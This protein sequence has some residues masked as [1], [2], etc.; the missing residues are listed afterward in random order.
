MAQ[1]EPLHGIGVVSTAVLVKP[2]QSSPVG[3]DSISGGVA[4]QNKL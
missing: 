2:C 4:A 3:E 1:H